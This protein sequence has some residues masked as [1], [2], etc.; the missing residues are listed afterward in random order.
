MVT[1]ELNIAENWL[2]RAEHARRRDAPTVP[3]VDPP[4]QR[5]SI[6]TTLHPAT[7]YAPH[8]HNSAML[9]T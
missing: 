3:P 6:V 8:V 5:P 9:G 4:A 7:G 1:S 2:L